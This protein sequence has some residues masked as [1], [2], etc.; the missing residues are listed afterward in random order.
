MKKRNNSGVVR[1][2]AINTLGGECEECGEDNKRKLVLHHKDGD[3]G[4]NEV[5]NIAVL[6]YS[7]HAKKHNNSENLN[8][9]GRESN[10]KEEE[11][12][13]YVKYMRRCPDRLI[14]TIREFVEKELG[15]NLF[16]IE[17][18]IEKTPFAYGKGVAKAI[19]FKKGIVLNDGRLRK[20]R[21]PDDGPLYAQAGGW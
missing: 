11:Y 4:N 7:C 21:G 12:G 19:L 18:I 13:K 2:I 15:R 9:I 3:P 10:W 1:E 14:P 16:D 8:D 5:S 20:K 17:G 6:C